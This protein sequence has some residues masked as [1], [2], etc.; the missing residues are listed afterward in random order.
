MLQVI[1]NS[2]VWM[3]KMLVCLVWNELALVMRLWCSLYLWAKFQ[4]E[5]PCF[6]WVTCYSWKWGSAKLWKIEYFRFGIL[7]KRI[8][9]FGLN[10]ISFVLPQSIIFSFPFP[11]TSFKAFF[12]G[13]RIRKW[14]ECFSSFS[15]SLSSLLSR[16]NKFNVFLLVVFPKS[17]IST[18]FRI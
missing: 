10:T 6:F 4:F 1:V 5:V 16:L 17:W 2:Y 7:L 13:F 8:F 14:N 12:Y 18:L 11:F 9:P 15:L 3:T